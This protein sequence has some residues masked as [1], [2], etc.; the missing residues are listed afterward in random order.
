MDTEN[1]ELEPIEEHEEQPGHA[2]SMLTGLVIGGLVGA[3]TMLLFAP[4]AGTRTRTEV[5]QG[6]LHL[7]DHTSERVKDK[8]TQV[9][10]K[11]NQLRTDVQTRTDELQHQ[12]R[13]LLTKQLERVSQAVEAGKKAL[14]TS[15]NGREA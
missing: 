6:A 1:Q 10:T 7:R 4:Q 2:K 5:Q 8:V 14:Q 3:G 15:S 12:G 11:A 9:K 13:D